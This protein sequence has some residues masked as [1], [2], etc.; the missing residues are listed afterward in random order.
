[1]REEIPGEGDRCDNQV[2]RPIVRGPQGA[3]T[4]HNAY[5]GSTRQATRAYH[6]M[7]KEAV[8]ARKATTHTLPATSYRATSGVRRAAYPA[9]TPMDHGDGTAATTRDVLDWTAWLS[10]AHAGGLSPSNVRPPI[11]Q[12]AGAWLEAHGVPAP[13]A[14]DKVDVAYIG[15]I[16]DALTE[17]GVPDAVMA[18]VRAHYGA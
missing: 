8:M 14:G 16:L 18:P 1:M 13:A 10:D 7:P 9:L 11:A 15:R 4:A 5:T 3:H 17:A 2:R 12:R 6:P